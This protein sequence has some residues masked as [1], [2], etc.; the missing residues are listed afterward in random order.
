GVGLSM[1]LEIAIHEQVKKVNLERS[2]SK[3]FREAYSGTTATKV[4]EIIVRKRDFGSIIVSVDDKVLELRQV[5]R[6]PNFVEFS[7]NGETVSANVSGRFG[8]AKTYSEAAS[9][10]ELVTANF[11]A[12]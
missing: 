6:T 12:K 9:V 10:N 7:I 8:V 3:D 4:S 1:K 2:V 5:R 11:P